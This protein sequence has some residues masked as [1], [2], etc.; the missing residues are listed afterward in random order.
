MKATFIGHQS[1]L[2]S[3]KNTYI[4]IDPLL[5]SVFGAS[6]R[7]FC[8]IFPF[9]NIDIAEM[10]KIDAI[11]LSHE[12]ADHFCIESLNEISPKP[13]V[14]VGA[15]ML[16][17]VKYACKKVGYDVKIVNELTPITIGSIKITLFH[18]DQSTPYWENRVYQ[19]LFEDLNSEASFFLAV[20]AAM[21]SN[22]EGMIERN[23]KKKPDIV[24][25][26]NNAQIT[27]YGRRS[28]FENALSL[29]SEVPAKNGPALLNV[30]DELLV[31]YL[32]GLPE[33]ENIAICGGGFIKGTED[34]SPPPFSDGALIVEKLNHVFS[35]GKIWNLIP[36]QVI[37]IKNHIVSTAQRVSWITLT[38]K[39]KII[40]D[41]GLPK[42]VSTEKLFY[43]YIQEEITECE[44]SD[45]KIRIRQCIEDML[46][47]ILLSEPGKFAFNRYIISNN[48]SPQID[49]IFS[50]PDLNISFKLSVD[51]CTGS[52]SES[53]SS[54]TAPSKVTMFISD[55]IAVLD[56]AVEIWDLTGSSVKIEYE[57]ENCNPIPFFYAYFGEHNQQNLAI[58]MVDKKISMGGRK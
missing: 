26:S 3:S 48:F 22:Y 41:F 36:G 43:P 13:P 49:F 45:A 32:K 51:L 14:Y 54:C 39:D 56:G 33:I 29:E 12:H 2:I 15:L 42:P 11:F 8:S 18:A 20:D 53:H 16:N 27:D 40:E 30:Y 19:L 6:E 10:P 50:T 35:S 58:K 31:S 5:K 7:S 47:G 21:S 44:L 46:P 4:L 23:D 1:W 55:F 28:A 24:A 57:N 38:T 52:I 37:S 17:N 34:L 25:V 9:R